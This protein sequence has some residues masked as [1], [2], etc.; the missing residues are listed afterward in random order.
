MRP[1]V[2]K[3]AGFDELLR[4]RIR[5]AVVTHILIVT[6]AAAPTA[7]REALALFAIV[8]WLSGSVLVLIVG[9]IYR[10]SLRHHR[11]WRRWRRRIIDTIALVHLEIIRIYK[12]HT[13]KLIFQRLSLFQNLR[14]DCPTRTIIHDMLSILT[15]KNNAIHIVRKNYESLFQNKNLNIVWRMSKLSTYPDHRT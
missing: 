12:I 1:W 15:Q 4:L 8:L 10:L 2:L 6:R 5:S 3:H 13:I 11:W 14:S 9:R 7:L